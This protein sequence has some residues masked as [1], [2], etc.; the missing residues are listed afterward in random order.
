MARHLIALIAGGIFGFGLSLSHMVDPNKVLDFLDLPGTWDPSLALVMGGALAVTAV[1]FPL[2]LRRPMPLFD[3]RFHMPT[4][5]AVDTR[6]LGGAALFGLG[7]GLSGY[8]PGP[9]LGA[10]VVNWQEGVPFVAAV[11]IG[12]MAVD[13]YELS[14]TARATVDG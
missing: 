14:R 9:A 8:C 10:I 12:G 4:T 2:I 6:L 1:T 11:V 7:W 13:F 3:Q 5:T